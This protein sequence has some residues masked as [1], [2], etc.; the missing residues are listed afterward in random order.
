MVVRGGAYLA[1]GENT[2]TTGDHKGPHSAQLHPRPYANHAG[3]QKYLP[4]KDP[5]ATHEDI[6][7]PPLER[8]ERFP[9]RP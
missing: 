2:G 9:H 1:L 4:L 7:K 8:G 5:Y 3:V 6:E